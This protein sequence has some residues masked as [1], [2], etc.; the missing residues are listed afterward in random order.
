MSVAVGRFRFLK[1][2][3]GSKL[4]RFETQLAPEPLEVDADAVDL[5][6]VLLNL[7]VNA[8]QAMPAGGVP[9]RGGS[10]SNAGL[11]AAQ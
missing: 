10:R 8:V 7:G 1:T 11:E 6:Q 4:V 2:Y 5:Q 3:P 9:A